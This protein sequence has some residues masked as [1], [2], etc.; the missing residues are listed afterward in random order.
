MRRAPGPPAWRPPGAPAQC[1]TPHAALHILALY[2]HT[3]THTHTHTLT[4]EK[5]APHASFGRAPSCTASHT[6]SRTACRVLYLDIDVHHGDGVEEAFLTTDRVMTVS[7][8]K[9]GGGYFPDTGDIHNCGQGG[10][11]L[12]LLLLLLLLRR[13]RRRRWYGVCV[14][15]GVFGVR[16]HAHACVRVCVCTRGNAGRWLAAA[17]AACRQGPGLLAQRSAAGRHHG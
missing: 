1:P 15:A 17:A 12:L 10:R 5:Q 6:A 16:G 11:R 13:R 14:H 3:H 9:F 7:F 2:A 4:R 8:H